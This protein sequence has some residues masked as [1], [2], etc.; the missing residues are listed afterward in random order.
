MWAEHRIFK[1]SSW[2]KFF[3][4]SAESV[5]V[6]MGVYLR[7]FDISMAEHFL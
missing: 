6:D 2:V 3:V 5:L 1:L 7:R 4:D